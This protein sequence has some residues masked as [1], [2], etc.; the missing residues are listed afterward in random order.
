M[1][2]DYF[3]IED[4]VEAY[5]SLVGGMKGSNIHGEAFKFSNEDP[6]SVLEIVDKV[7]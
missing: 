4:S 7:Q 6:M 5:L 3:Y 1:V 2:R